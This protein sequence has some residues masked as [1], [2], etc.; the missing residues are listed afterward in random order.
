MTELWT[1]WSGEVDGLLVDVRSCEVRSLKVL[2]RLTKSRQ[3]RKSDPTQSQHRR[4]RIATKV[5]ASELI[6]L[7]KL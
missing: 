5:K 2:A 1:E 7:G 6:A 4:R 3:P